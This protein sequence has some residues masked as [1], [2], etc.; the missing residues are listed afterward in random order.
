MPNIHSVVCVIFVRGPLSLGFL[1]VQC[2][3]TFK[4]SDAAYVLSYSVIMLNTDQ[5]NKQVRCHQPPFSFDTLRVSRC[6]GDSRAVSNS[7]RVMNALGGLQ[8]KKKMTLEQF[9]RNNRGIN[10][11]EG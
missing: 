1:C 3:G 2:P 11:G 8:V 5:H 10:D 9:I 7:C 4:N 6:I